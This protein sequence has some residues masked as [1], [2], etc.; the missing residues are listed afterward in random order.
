MSAT[1]PSHGLARTHVSALP[2]RRY[3]A[4]CFCGIEGT[5][6]VS[7]VAARSN[8]DVRHITA[9]VELL[10][11]SGVAALPGRTVHPITRTETTRTRVWAD[12]GVS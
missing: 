6:V 3:T 1:T 5:S 10:T 4:T 12:G 11:A 8:M 7:S 2:D 9:A